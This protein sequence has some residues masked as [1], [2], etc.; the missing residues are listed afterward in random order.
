MEEGLNSH[1]IWR[2]AFIALPLVLLILW[3]FS[4]ILGAARPAL[5]IVFLALYLL[6]WAYGFLWIFEKRNTIDLWK[7]ISLTILCLAFSVL[8]SMYIYWKYEHKI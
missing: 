4:P 6:V 5:A 1:R 8:F 3:L 7:T 2:M